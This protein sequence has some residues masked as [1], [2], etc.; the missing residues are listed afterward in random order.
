MEIYNKTLVYIAD[1][2]I[3][4]EPYNAYFLFA[5]VRTLLEVYVKFLNFESSSLDRGRLALMCLCSQLLSIKLSTESVYMEIQ[6][7]HYNLIK[8]AKLTFPKFSD[9]DFVWIK[10]NKLNFSKKNDLLTIENINKHSIKTVEVFKPRFMYEVYQAFS[11]FI[12]GNPYYQAMNER[13][14]AV[15]QCLIISS[16]L[17]E[18]IDIRTLKKDGA[19]D[20]RIWL[21]DVKNERLL[22]NKLW[23][24]NGKIVI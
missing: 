19:T 8:S 17:L 16:F 4:G 13:Y 15:T 3:K 11:E 24:K 12:H 18:I 6:N 9:F 5:H 20:F 21:K 22:I 10:N 2:I 14:W 1:E 7:L 23:P